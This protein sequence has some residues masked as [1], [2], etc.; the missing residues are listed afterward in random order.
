MTDWEK[1]FSVAECTICRELGNDWKILPCGHSFCFKCLDL[2]LKNS[3]N[4]LFNC[5]SC[6]TNFFVPAGGVGSLTKDIFKQ[7]LSDYVR[8]LRMNT[9]KKSPIES[10]PCSWCE[11]QF[12]R[13]YCVDCGVFLCPED[14]KA[15]SRIKIYSQHNV[16]SEEGGRQKQETINFTCQQHQELLQFYC[17]TCETVICRGRKIF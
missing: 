9:E 2:R 10:N 14:V 1:T 8:S 5:P 6:R 17:E 7:T 4:N 15:H 12:S 3:I 13:A 16:I 11:D